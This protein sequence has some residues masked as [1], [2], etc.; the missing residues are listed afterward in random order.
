VNTTPG[1]SAAVPRFRLLTFGTLRLVGTAD[2]TVLGEHGHQRRR[3]ALLAVLAAYGEG[4]RSR[5][6]LLGLFWPE[7]SQSRARHSLQQLLYAIRTSLNES[8]FSGSNPLRLNA[9]VVGSDIGDFTDALSRDE[10]AAAVEL[11]RGPFLE[12]F[13]LGDAPEFEQWMETERGRLERRYT[14]ALERLAKRAEDAN[15]PAAAARWLQKLIETDPLSSKHAI[16]LIRALMNA[17]DHTA[18]LRYA[19]RYE[20]IVGQELGTSVGPA[21]AG[22]VAEVRARAK[23][24]SVIVRGGPSPPRPQRDSG[25]PVPA[26]RHDAPAESGDGADTASPVPSFG[27]DPP[28]GPREVERDLTRRAPARRR[29]VALYAIAG[30]ALAALVV[31]IAW[32]RNRA[33]E[34]PVPAVAD[35]SIAVLPLA[36]LSGDSRDAALVD[37]LSEELI[38][39]LAKIDRLRVVARTSA[40]VFKNSDLDV[41]RIADSLNVSN[42]LEGGVQKSGERL[43]VQVRLVDARDGSTRWSDTYDRELKDI[44]QVQ[45]E[46]ATAVAG[47]LDL[48]LGTGGRHGVRRQSTQNIAAYELYLRGSDPVLLRS[49]SSARVGL[50]YFRR[51]IA[52][53]STY[54]AAYAGLA[55]MY[56]RLR[57]DESAARPAREF[58]ALGRQ[59]ALKAVELDDSLAE[60]HAVVGMTRM[61]EYDIAGAEV[62]LKRAVMI[63]PGNSRTREWL[64]FVYHW[65]GRPADALA[66]VNRAVE[67]D[68]LSPSA[69]A[70]VAY[71]LCA[72]HQPA[73]GLARLKRVEQVQPPLLRVPLYVGLCHGINADWPA[74]IAALAQSRGR[75]TRGVLGHALAR[76]GRREEALTILADLTKEWQR[77]NRGA[78]EIALVQGG[79]GKHDAAVEWL[80]RA[81]EDRSLPVQAHFVLHLLPDLAQDPRLRRRLRL[82]NP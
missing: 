64:A 21:V 30:M 79:L 73:Q 19:E 76:A 42:I 46:I 35:A 27:D 24:E 68:P 54:A 34:G 13:W 70:E 3:L 12:G 80:E 59:A 15:D 9:A 32:P 33:A 10:L 31:A 17:G 6:Q 41:R 63:D 74:A 48:R 16:G 82:Q 37:G 81:M 28:P 61:N 58:H 14:D 57:T 40:F 52:L 23:T 44:F 43:R 47:E 66:E 4:G 26:P 49:D 62:E 75:L 25:S 55:R 11:Y 18:A 20:S 78:F 56:L 2:D 60:A 67:N 51:A 39:T 65:R 8:V 7:V 22:L 72:N 1:A 77:A 5:D 36:N 69:H 50:E 45:S 71:A 53:D 38:G 29:S